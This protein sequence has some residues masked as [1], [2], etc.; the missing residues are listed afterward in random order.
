MKESEKASYWIGVVSALHV[1]QGVSGGF[2]Q[3]CHGKSAPLRKMKPGDWL[4]YYSPRTEIK[5]GE[6]L[7]AF[8]AIGKVKDE[9]VYEYAMSE[10]FVP[11]RR[12]IEYM[13]CEEARIRELLDQ[14]SFTRGK[15]NWGYVF[16][17]GHFEISQADF[18]IIAEAMNVAVL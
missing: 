13:P 4:V 3:M 7:Q 1:Q 12:D 2:A 9:H 5:G 16:R 10:T 11:Y 15:P 17:T 6:P 14:L 8:T 18:C